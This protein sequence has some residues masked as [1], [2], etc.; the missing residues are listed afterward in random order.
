MLRR[1]MIAAVMA[2]MSGPA[3]ADDEPLLCGDRQRIIGMI[4]GDWGLVVLTTLDHP[5]MGRIEIWG[6]MQSGLWTM[7]TEDGMGK[8]CY[9]LTGHGFGLNFSLHDET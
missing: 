8:T 6:S 3:V 9:F 4:S 2:L 1:L 7:L 5:E